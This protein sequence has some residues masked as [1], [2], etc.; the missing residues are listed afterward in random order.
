MS[1]SPRTSVH[2]P[3]SVVGDIAWD[4]ALITGQRD[5]D[6]K[7]TATS[8]YRGVGGTAANTAVVAAHLGTD[9]RLF[10][11]IGTDLTGDVVLAG[12]SHSGVRLEGIERAEGDTAVAVITIGPDGDRTVVVDRGVADEL[13]HA[14][15][16]QVGDGDAVVY[17]ANVPREVAEGYLDAGV[18]TLVVGVESR[19]V[20]TCSTR[21]RDLLGRVSVSVMNRHAADHLGGRDGLRQLCSESGATVLVTLGQEGSVLLTPEE[22]FTAPAP[23][24]RVVDATGAGDCLAGVFCHCIASSVDLGHA[25]RLATVAASLSTR[26]IG[27]QGSLPDLVEIQRHL[28][29]F[30]Q[31]WVGAS[32]PSR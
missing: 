17:L 2:R 1:G 31:T 24:V 29:L 32:G 12:L 3:L 6:E 18:E 8:S 14:D 25:T 22:E 15:P 20:A 30:E 16:S 5:G 23:I 11:S 9:T 21:W 13:A 26:V 10:G 19:Q 7:V 4:V 27:A 28:A